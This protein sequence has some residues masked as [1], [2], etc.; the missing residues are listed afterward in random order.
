MIFTLTNEPDDL[1]HDGKVRLSIDTY[2]DV[3]LKILAA[4][5]ELVEEHKKAKARLMLSCYGVRAQR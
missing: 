1:F 4:A 3:A 5:Q 2:P